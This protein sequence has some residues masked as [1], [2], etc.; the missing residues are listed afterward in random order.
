MLG[1]FKSVAWVVRVSHLHQ[2]IHP[3]KYIKD[4]FIFKS[5]IYTCIQYIHLL[6][7]KYTLSTVPVPVHGFDVISLCC[8]YI[9]TV[10]VLGFI[11][12]TV[13]DIIVT[14]DLSRGNNM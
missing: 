8:P 12:Y 11:F 1:M 4:I 10:H 9:H 6:L 3:K 5:Q 7:S 13:Y 2:H 14:D